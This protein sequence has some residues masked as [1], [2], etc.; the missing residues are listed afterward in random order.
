MFVSTS[1]WRVSFFFLIGI[2]LI[3]MALVWFLTADKPRQSKQANLA[4]VEYIESA[5]Q[6]ESAAHA[7]KIATTGGTGKK[8]YLDYRY[9]MITFAFLCS[10]SMFW[11][12]MAWLPSYLKVARGFTWAQMG[13]LSSLPY[14]LGTVTV[15]LFGYIADRSNRKAIFPMIA[16]GSGAICMYLGANVADNVTSAYFISAAIGSLGI[17]L[18]SYWA[19]MQTIVPASSMGTAAGIMNG[20]A[21]IGSAFVPTIVGIFIQATGGSYASGLMFLVGMAALGCVCSL[22][23][24]LKR[25]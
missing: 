14:I 25:I 10:A 20:V 22:V 11:G 16:L 17:G 19:I 24:T 5:L 9:W 13:S 4:E 15:L 12:T 7:A 8:F 2:S 18:A 23:L 3:P 1:G 6:A 21:S